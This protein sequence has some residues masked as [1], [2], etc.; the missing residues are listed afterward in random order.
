M[1][2]APCALTPEPMESPGTRCHVGRPVG[3]GELTVPVSYSSVW[4]KSPD[5]LPLPPCTVKHHHHHFFLSVSILYR[6][7]SSHEWRKHSCTGVTLGNC[8]ALMYH[9]TVTFVRGD[10]VTLS[11]RPR[12]KTYLVMWEVTAWL[13]SINCPGL[14]KLQFGDEAQIC[15]QMSQLSWAMELSACFGFVCF[16]VLNRKAWS[17]ITSETGTAN[18]DFHQPWSFSK[19]WIACRILS[20]WVHMPHWAAHGVIFLTAVCICVCAQDVYALCSVHAL[21][22]TT[23]QCVASRT[24]ME[25]MLPYGLFCVC[26]GSTLGTGTCA[27]IASMGHRRVSAFLP[28]SKFSPLVLT[29]VSEAEDSTFALLPISPPSSSIQSPRLDHNTWLLVTKQW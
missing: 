5:I 2:F 20:C 6:N 25:N 10:L 29:A 18:Q 23:R 15:F 19:I 14:W 13:I 3:V 12:D 17:T 4:F 28:I 27:L 26:H 24:A 21:D 1:W 8:V 16:L 9:C 11:C 22:R 7:T